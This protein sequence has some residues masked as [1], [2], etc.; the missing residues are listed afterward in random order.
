VSPRTFASAGLAV[1]LAAVLPVSD[2]LAQRSTRQHQVTV[3]V[4]DRDGQPVPD[5]KPADFVVKEDG[6][7]REV[8]KVETSSTP[9]QISVLVDT[10]AGTQLIMPDLRKAVQTFVGLVWSKSPESQ[11]EL[12]EFGERPMQLVDFT[13]TP[14]LIE[15]GVGRLFEHPGSGAYMLEAIDDASKALK[16]RE[17]ERPVIAVFVNSDS[18]EF[19]NQQYAQIEDALKASKAALWAIVL[20]DRPGGGS[21]RRNREIVLGDVT[22]RSGGWREVV[23]DKMGLER[24]FEQLASRLTTQYVVTYSRPEELI[25]PSRLDVSVSRPNTQLIA[26]HWTGQ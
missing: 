1:L 23:L 15:R 21:E 5:M 14:A 9:M 10:S 22:T 16:K 3:S 6:V 25:P 2:L 24:E 8:L 13:K 4:L 20:G 7:A 12:R 17:A 26:P 11:I 18:P 19:S